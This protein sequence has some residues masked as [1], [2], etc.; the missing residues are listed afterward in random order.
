MNSNR[1]G[2]LLFF[3]SA[4]L[5][6]FGWG[7]ATAI[8]KFFPYGVV[9]EAHLAFAALRQSQTAA[10]SDP[11]RFDTAQSTEPIS[12]PRGRWLVAGERGDRSD[13]LILISGGPEFLAEQFP[14]EGCL[15]WITDRSGKVRHAWKLKRE[16]EDAIVHEAGVVLPPQAPRAQTV[17]VGVHLFENGDLLATFHTRSGFPYQ[18]GIAKFDRES[19]LLWKVPRNNHHWFSVDEQGH[20]H[21][22]YQRLREAPIPLGGTRI[23]LV[24]EEGKIY[25][26]G[27]MVLDPE[28]QIIEEFSVLDSLVD[29]GYI[30]L[31][32]GKR[33]KPQT[34]SRTSARL[35]EG[36]DPVHLNDVRLISEDDLRLDPSLA[37][38]D[39]L[40]SMRATNAVAVLDRKTHLVKWLSSGTTAAQHS[41]RV[42]G[43]GIL[44]FDNWGGAESTGGTRLALVD[45]HH[46]STQTVF[47]RPD[48]EL[49]EP[50]FSWEAGHIDVHP[51]GRRALLA[52]TTQGVVWEVDLKT[53][54]VLWEYIVPY[55]PTLSRNRRR[56][57]TA[58]YCGRLDFPLG[59]ST[60]AEKS[61]AAAD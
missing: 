50:F 7:M 45:W 19:R 10:E 60:M 61:D 25:D 47:P 11:D 12:G 58:K 52:S 2:K 39:Y 31:F 3:A 30:A 23:Q 18:T 16:F 51:N 48:T 35:I 46:G 27:I 24:A 14:P 32:K 55:S 26:E 29:S 5:L 33:L 6:I 28:G 20:I 17:P 38:G 15:A 1:I 49:P 36:S 9:K 22:P 42:F 59:Q 4:A 21:V 53:G 41:P 56:I 44:V 34:G 43:S 54:A 13:E 37:V 40:I 8:F 57:H